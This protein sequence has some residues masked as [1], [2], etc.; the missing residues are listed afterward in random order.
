MKK[1]IIS[2]L[3]IIL[4][5]V[6]IFTGC[7]FTALTGGPA[8]T[9]AVTSNGGLVVQKGNYIYYTR[10]YTSTSSFSTNRAKLSAIYRSELN[11]DGSLKKDD[12]GNNITELLANK[13]VGFE[14]GG[15]YIFGDKIYYAT[16]HTEADNAGEHDY[17]KTDFYESNLDGTSVKRIYST[18]VGS[19]S[20][21]FAFYQVDGEVYLA[22]FDSADLFVITTSSK[23]VNKVA[24]GVKSVVLPKISESNSNQDASEQGKRHIYYTRAIDSEA[25]S[26]KNFKKGNVLAM[27]DIVDQ[28]EIVIASNSTFEVKDFKLDNLIYTEK[29][30]NNS[31]AYYYM[32]SFSYTNNEAKVDVSNKTKLTYQ[33]YSNSL[34]VLE[35]EDGYRGMITENESGYLTWIK[36]PQNDMPVFEILT[37]EEK[38]TPIAVYNNYVFA[39]NSDKELYMIKYNDTSKLYKLTSKDSDTLSFEMNLNIDFND[40]YVYFYKSFEG[41]SE[42]AYY[43]VRVNT[44]RTENFEVEL[45]GTLLDEHIKTEE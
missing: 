3:M 1:K 30:Q 45:V 20:F 9:D 19:T 17:T 6:L 27:A 4:V 29:D 12:D 31:N 44:N 16:P 14:N 26:D 42:S 13:V 10:A 32:A 43:L 33:A 15:F 40:G 7:G 41:N 5:G 39:Y 36:M 37:T 28:T 25:E 21:K 34:I 23:N 38:L 35:F 18:Q 24:T 11:S 2:F 22:V 8:S